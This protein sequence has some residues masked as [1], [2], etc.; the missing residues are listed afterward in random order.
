MTPA[1]Q[2]HALELVENIRD[3]LD[4]LDT[5]TGYL[6]QHQQ[7]TL[8][9]VFDIAHLIHVEADNLAALMYGA[10][11]QPDLLATLTEAAA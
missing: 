11:I 7:V 6:Q 8:K 9:P 1:Q 3:L 4:R 5:E 2:H 10:N